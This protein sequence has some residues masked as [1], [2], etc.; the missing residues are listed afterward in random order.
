MKT[1]WL[2]LLIATLWLCMSSLSWSQAG[3]PPAGQRVN[4]VT[5]NTLSAS[6]VESLAQQLER[7]EQQTGARLL[8]LIVP[9]LQGEPIENYSQR[10]FEAWRPGRTGVDDGALLVLSRGDRKMRIHLGRGLESRL[11]YDAT[12]RI[13]SSYMV[14]AFK[15]GN[16]AQGFQDAITALDERIRMQRP[17][18]STPMVDTSPVATPLFAP[19]QQAPV[20]Q[21]TEPANVVTPAPT[22]K[23]PAKP[24]NY[25]L[26]GLAAALG[27][28][29]LAFVV[30][31]VISKRKFE[32]ERER[33]ERQ[34]LDR[35][36]AADAEARRVADLETRERT[37]KAALEVQAERAEDTARERLRQ[38]AA[39]ARE[40][41]RAS[42]VKPQVAAPVSSRSTVSKPY[43]SSP[44]PA[45]YRPAP[46]PAPAP[47]SRSAPS[48]SDYG[49]SRS[50][51]APAPSYRR[52]D[53]DDRRSSW[54]SSW[55]SSSSS[56]SDDSSSGGSSSGA[57][58]SDSY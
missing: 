23:E 17:A 8:V 53:D 25:A 4:D 32:A 7:V 6:Q 42:G 40:A 30:S 26:I 55:S 13:T 54:G 37:R 15:A 21:L 34:E 58:S 43:A 52:D 39:E 27:L 10:V 28:G 24:V 2:K 16:F 57:G 45:S 12:K 47:A 11:P 46:R 20:E 38:A 9:S 22:P 5:G 1:Q 36:R 44:A 14:P 56:S 48:S 19:A 33:R 31:A 29:F 49:Y 41:Q 51:P 35:Q 3:I 50:A 18:P